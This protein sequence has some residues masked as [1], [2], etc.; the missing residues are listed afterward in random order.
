MGHTSGICATAIAPRE[1]IHR[2]C[3]AGG[4]GVITESSAPAGRR[5]RRGLM[6]RIPPILLEQLVSK[7][8]H[9]GDTVVA[10]SGTSN[11]LS[12]YAVRQQD[13][14][15]DLLIINKSSTSSQSPTINFTGFQPSGQ[16][17]FWQYGE[18]QD[19][20]QSQTKNGSAACW[21]ISHSRW[22]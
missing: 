19:T 1:I 11:M 20:A 3:M 14:D 8:V 6:Y 5:R 22:R 13:G 21:R 12:V 10:V 2:V 7:M 4:R 18:A 15:M 17:T 16:A 9:N